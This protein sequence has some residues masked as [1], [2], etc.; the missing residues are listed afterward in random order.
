M[1]RTF[2][3]LAFFLVSGGLLN[4][5]FSYASQK[6]VF[7]SLWY[8]KNSDVFD[9]KNVVI[10]TAS[11]FQSAWKK[12]SETDFGIANT[13]PEVDFKNKKVIICYAGSQTNGLQI[14]STTVSNL[15]LT[16]HERNISM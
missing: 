14:D 13:P 11:E 2:Y 5:Y 8:G 1:K 12:L 10:S 4:F 3:C 16:I 7:Q 15:V 9:K 6:I